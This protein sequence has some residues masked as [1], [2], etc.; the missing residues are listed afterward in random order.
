M[1]NDRYGFGPLPQIEEAWRQL[2]ES[3]IEIESA[4][5]LARFWCPTPGCGFLVRLQRSDDILTC[6][7][8]QKYRATLHV[9]VKGPLG[10]EVNPD[11]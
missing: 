4:A 2:F 1:T 7:C 8:G 9:A 5:P 10:A 3:E 11:A 6:H